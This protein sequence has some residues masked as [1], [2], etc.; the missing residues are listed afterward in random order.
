VFDCSTLNRKSGVDFLL[1][2]PKN[3]ELFGWCSILFDSCSKS[4]R[5][6]ISRCAVGL[7]SLFRCVVVTQVLSLFVVL[8]F[9]CSLFSCS[10]VLLVLFD[11]PELPG[12]CS[13][14]SARYASAMATEGLSSIY[15]ISGGRGLGFLCRRQCRSRRS[16]P[17]FDTV[18]NW[19]QP[20][21]L[22]YVGGARRLQNRGKPNFT[23]VVC[24]LSSSVALVECIF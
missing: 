16:L 11:Y 21:L 15:T 4:G 24:F 22:A 17:V 23:V 6:S 13:T 1:S 2:S 19:F 5:K 10:A 7:L 3:L 20:V 8:L 9:S 14:R 12:L 18:G